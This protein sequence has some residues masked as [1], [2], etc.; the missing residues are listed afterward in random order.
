MVRCQL[1]AD[2]GPRRHEVADAL[3]A[4][5]VELG[6]A[7]DAAPGYPCVVFV[8]HVALGPGVIS[9]VRSSGRDRV[10]ALLPAGLDSSPDTVWSL[11][12]AGADDVLTWR[13]HGTAGEIEA[14]LRRWAEVDTL[15]RSTEVSERL[16]GRSPRWRAVLR[17]LVET[18]R[19][20]DAN[21]LL[22]GESGT[23]KELAARAI[24][25]LSK[26]T[27]KGSF[28]IVDC[29]TVVPTLS[30]S[31]FFGHERGAFT[32]AVSARDGAFALADG[33]T[34]FLDEVGE[35]PLQLQAELLRVV[36]EGTYKRVGSNVWQRARFR[37]VCATNRDLAEEEAQG[38][39]RRDFYFRIAGS[40]IRLPPLRERRD[41]ILPLF[42]RFLGAGTGGGPA[43]EA[44]VADLLL[45]RDYPGNVREL[46]QLASR[47]ANRHVGP[48]PLTAGDIPQDERPGPVRPRPWL[49]S[50]FEADTRRALTLGYGLR[51][52]PQVAADVAVRVAL[53]ETSGHV[54]RAAHL[55]GVTSRALHL[56]LANS[57]ARETGAVPTNGASS[58]GGDGLLGSEPGIPL[59]GQGENAS[60]G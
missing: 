32:G 2:D 51:E 14:R 9:R 23:G 15:V 5:G 43:I 25:E 18:A 24:H 57:R 34:L 50:A 21:V 17:E 42:R 49:E 28:V 22:I 53:E 1:V 8:E 55:L 30:G 59:D 29:T 13:G 54:G 48:G 7:Q 16:V 56:R 11:L 27:R 46:R 35:L 19:F 45:S 6:E 3:G 58:P 4:K 31:E 26:G 39:F 44:S 12:G 37:L 38:R 33:G 36:Q 52:I 10:L 60:A 41:D 47:V 20:T 40:V